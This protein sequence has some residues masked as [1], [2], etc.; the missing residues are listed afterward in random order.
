M[1][2]NF[3]HF[4]LTIIIVAGFSGNLFAQHEHTNDVK[5]QYSGQQD[6]EI[7]SLSETEIEGLKSGAGTPFNGMAKPA[8]LNGYPGPRHVLDA[9]EAG[10]FD[11]NK[12]QIV[13]IRQLFKN[14]Q[15]KAIPLGEQ[16]IA[17]EKKMD[18]AFKIKDIS[19][20]MLR[21]MISKSTDLYAE[22]RFVHL[23]THLQMVDI[24]TQQQVQAYNRMRGYTS[25]DPCE[26]IPAGHDPEMWKRH[27]GC[28]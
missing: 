16:I 7:A 1:K 23:N 20:G 19:S 21:E 6:R 17:I 3:N 10:S 2:I 11:L 26:N 28:D 5:S 9:Y 24:L 14:M 27:N 13:Q 8:E 25:E 22:L 4:V 18:N 15:E 12:D